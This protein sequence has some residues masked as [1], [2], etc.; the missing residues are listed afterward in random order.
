LAAAEN[1]GGQDKGAEEESLEGHYGDRTGDDRQVEGVTF[2]V[3]EDGPWR[4]KVALREGPEKLD[5]VR[6]ARILTEEVE[7]EVEVK[8]AE[9]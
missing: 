3:R 9:S 5:P 8:E 1:K 7:E 4:K 6:R 2:Q